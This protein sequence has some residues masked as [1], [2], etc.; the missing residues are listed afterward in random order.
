MA[1]DIRIVSWNVRGLNHKLKRAS[2]FQY[3]KHTRPHV[4][5][6]QETHLDGSRIL[7][8]RKP[9]IQRAFHSTYSTFARG[10]SILI[11]KTIPCT[12]HQVISDTG[13]R[14]VAVVSDLCQKTIVLVNIY[15]PPPFQAKML[16]DLLNKIAPFAHLPVVLLGDFNAVLDAALDTSNPARRSSVDLNGWKSV[17]DLTE[18]WRWKHPTVTSF[19]HVSIT[20]RSSARIDLAFGNNLML[21]FVKDISYLAGGLTDHNPLEVILTFV[22]GK[23]GGEYGACH[24]VGCKMNKLLLS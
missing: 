23:T 11:S 5:L 18:L 17:A 14:Y 8:L 13:G 15:V 7:S 20:H 21:P 4:V 19:S 9:W 2:V 1:N 16:Y 12:I 22:S 10:L 3:L 6:L 24:L